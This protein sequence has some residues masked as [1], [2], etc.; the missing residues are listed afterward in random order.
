MPKIFTRNTLIFVLIVL[1]H[2][3]CKMMNL[4]YSGF[5]YEEAFNLYFSEQDW[6]LIKHTSE[7]NLGPPLYYY[8]LSIWRNL[9]GVSE[10]AIRF[11]SVIFSALA[12]GILYLFVIKNFDRTAAIISVL[13]FSVS[14]QIYN[15]SQEAH[16]YSIVLFLTLSSV[17][18]FYNLLDKK[19]WISIIFL[20]LCNFLLLYSYYAS[21]TI[22]II[23]FVTVLIFF[24]KQIFQRI[25]LA[26]LIT[27]T[28]SYLRFTKK[29]IELIFEQVE[30]SGWAQPD[31]NELKGAFYEYFNG[32]NLFWII[33]SIATLSLLYLFFLRRAFGVFKENKIKVSHVFFLCVGSIALCFVINCFMPLVLNVYFIFTA[34]FFFMFIG[35]LISKS[36]KE[37]KFV[38][39]GLVCFFSLISFSRINFHPAKSINYRSAVVTIK[40]LQTEETLTLIET[41][42]VGHLF[43]YYYDRNIFTDFKNMSN[44]LEKKGIYLISSEED[45]I[46]IDFSKYNRLVLAQTFEDINPG[47]KKLVKFISDK[48]KYKVS[49]KY[50]RGV[51]ISLFQKQTTSKHN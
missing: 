43:A 22:I 49:S 30:A 39:V 15:F 7:W 48:F 14:N 3:V 12:A 16:V 34:P 24:R 47:D 32:F 21:I 44:R 18:L 4:D 28:L 45:L 31:I 37:I 10:F 33:I 13:L 38:V 40:R 27:A 9:F 6:G 25:G 2:V 11:S 51:A 42:D 50:F 46:T 23:Q 17:Y 19:N 29:S 36:V 8:F 5:G 1:F 26:L 41:R 20:G 35:L